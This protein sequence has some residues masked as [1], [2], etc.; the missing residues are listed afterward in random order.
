LELPLQWELQKENEE[1]DEHDLFNTGTGFGVF[2]ELA[3]ASIEQS[4]IRSWIQESKDQG[5]SS[6]EAED[7][8]CELKKREIVGLI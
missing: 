5:C 7:T 8:S 2:T 3:I 1:L 4:L 6:A